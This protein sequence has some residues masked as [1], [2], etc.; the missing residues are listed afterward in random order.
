MNSLGKEIEE[1]ALMYQIQLK[2][3]NPQRDS[4][5]IWDIA[6]K[7]AFEEVLI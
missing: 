1:K 4:K 3:E 5:E 6:E 7:M 2:K